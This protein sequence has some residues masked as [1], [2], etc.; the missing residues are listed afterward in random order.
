MA[1]SR[2]TVRD[3]GKGFELPDR[4]DDLASA[5]KLGLLGMQERARLLGGSLS[6]Q[7]R[8]GEGTTIAVAVP[9]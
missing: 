1:W 4:I 3:N 7:S 8:P 5:G 6:V 9:V 2:I